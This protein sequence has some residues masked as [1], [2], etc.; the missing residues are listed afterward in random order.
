[1]KKL[2]ILL[3]FIPLFCSAQEQIEY[4]LSYKPSI[5]DELILAQRRWYAAII[6]SAVGGGLVTLSFF[7]DLGGGVN[8][9]A[10]IGSAMQLVS[11]GLIINSWSHIGRAG[12]LMNEKKIGLTFNNGIGLRYRI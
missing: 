11:V 6:T 10:A 5:G 8:G 7:V 12:K 3:A 1:M 4:K 2:I 9:I